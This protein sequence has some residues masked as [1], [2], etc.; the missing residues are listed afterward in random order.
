M[1]FKF[2][3][4]NL[5]KELVEHILFIGERLAL[6]MCMCHKIRRYILYMTTSM[7]FTN[8]CIKNVDT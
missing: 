4:R 6:N 8:C 7:L 1:D 2:S 5:T 3:P